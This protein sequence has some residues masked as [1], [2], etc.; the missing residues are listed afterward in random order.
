MSDIAKIKE[1]RER[2]GIGFGDCKKA[3]AACDWDVEKAID[4]IRKQSAVKA[5]KKADRTAAEGRLAIKIAEDGKSGAIV[6]IN[7][8]T[9][10]AARNERFGAFCDTVVDTVLQDGPA[11]LDALDGLRKELVQTIG[12]NVTLRRADRFASS[13]DD[14]F[15]SSYLHTNGVVGTLVEMSR[16]DEQTARD[17]AMHV[18]ASE[19][20][21]VSAEDLP[22]SVV[23]KEREILLEQA[24]DSGKPESI[25]EKMVEGRLRKFRAESCLSEQPFVKDP[26][27]KVGAVLKSRNA[28]CERFVRYQVGEGIEKREDDLAAEVQKLI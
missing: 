28:A 4:H 19:P 17:V 21:V 22:E 3:L 20:L 12:E 5:A 16:G 14:G 24:R 15:V 13:S 10:F 26:E 27:Q 23:A 9:D 1:I 7:V 18:T 2:T 25:I 6:E 11:S 8:E